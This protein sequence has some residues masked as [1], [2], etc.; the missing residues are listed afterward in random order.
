MNPI[1][2][3][4]RTAISLEKSEVP[5]NY[6]S[7]IITIGSCFSDTIGKFLYDN[8]FNCLVNPFGTLFNPISIF[9][10]IENSILESSYS[11][12]NE[13]NLNSGFA[14]YA[15]HSRF[16]SENQKELRA[17]IRDSNNDFKEFLFSADILIITL[18]T[19]WVHVLKE[20]G[21]IV[22]NCHKQS[23]KNFDKRLLS[24][25][26]IKDRFYQLNKAL[27]ENLSIIFTLSPVR[28]TKEGLP[29]NQLSKSIL[30][31]AIHQIQEENSK[32]DYFPS[33]EIMIDDLRD[34]RFYK[35]DLIHPNKTA[36]KYIEN[37]F[38]H[39]YFDNSTNEIV[40][41]WEKVKT[42]M[43]HKSFNPK[44]T[45]NIVFLEK[46]LNDLEEINSQIVVKEEIN[47]IKKRL[48]K[49]E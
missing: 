6:S 46:L 18:G 38:K 12:K 17:S 2:I 37:A 34:Y 11:E 3:K 4:L 21:E 24:S 42:R 27:P 20:N 31:N 15:Y 5:I 30:R 29:E 1:D 43:K 32:I 45:E 26:E 22:A 9:E 7:K 8:K 13:V 44:S 14:N 19:A 49:N 48:I 28:H 36:I 39:C 40:K 23:K 16:W 33:Y 25:R 10:T 41:K 35:S 47:E